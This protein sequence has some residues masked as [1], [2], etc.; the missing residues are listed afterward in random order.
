MSTGGLSGTVTGTRDRSAVASEQAI[1]RLSPLSR[2]SGKSRSGLAGFP[3]EQ[4]INREWVCA[5]AP[6]ITANNRGTT[7]DRRVIKCTVG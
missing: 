7:V 3:S 6:V 5:I 1:N 2:G 4:G